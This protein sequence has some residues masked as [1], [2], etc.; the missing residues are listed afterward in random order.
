MPQGKQLQTLA[1]YRAGWGAKMD[2]ARRQARERIA[3]GIPLR[4]K[5]AIGGKSIRRL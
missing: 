1:D 2:N 3:A 4:G 5:S